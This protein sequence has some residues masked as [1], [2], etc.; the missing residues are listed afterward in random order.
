MGNT[1]SLKRLIKAIESHH[2]EKYCVDRKL[3]VATLKTILMDI[4]E[5][6]GVE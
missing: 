1:D 3:L 6:R 5:K 4:E 2:D